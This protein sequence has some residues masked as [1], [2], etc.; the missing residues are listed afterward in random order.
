MIF[1]IVRDRICLREYDEGHVIHA[2]GHV[3]KDVAHPAAAL[4]MLL[5]R[6]GALHHRPD[7][8][9]FGRAPEG[10]PCACEGH[11]H[12]L[13]R[14]TCSK[15]VDGVGGWHSHRCGKPIKATVPSSYTWQ[16]GLCAEE[17]E[18]VGVEEVGVCGLH[19]AGYRRRVEN[20]RRR[21]EEAAAERERWRRDDETK[22][23]LV[24]TAERLRPLLESLG[25]RPDALQVHSHTLGLPG[26]DLA[27]LVD[28]AV[29]GDALR[30][31]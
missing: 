13:G 16:W 12:Q 24:E 4:A 31:L 10:A 17:V 22:R 23:S 29:E 5:K 27:H 1:E 8:P 25:L 30:N 2:S 14:D 19:A 28:L 11:G 26:E 21:S 9:R 7:G 6:E 3:R 18:E 20:D 15:E